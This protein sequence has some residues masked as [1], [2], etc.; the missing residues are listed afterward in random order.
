M[1]LHLN[2]LSLSISGQTWIAQQTSLICTHS[3][4]IFVMV[5]TPR[6]A[7]LV[8]RTA[9]YV[10]EKLGHTNVADCRGLS[11]ISKLIHY[12]TRSGSKTLFLSGLLSPILAN[13]KILK[14]IARV[15]QERK[16]YCRLHC[17]HVFHEMHSTGRQRCLMHFQQHKLAWS[18]L[19]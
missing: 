13:L 19:Y 12:H 6:E 10:S 3:Q 16:S 1:R 9:V 14:G 15:H 4:A 11:R 17:S 8:E 5:Q 2:I 7:T 18:C